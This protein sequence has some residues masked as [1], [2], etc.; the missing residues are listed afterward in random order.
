M[1]RLK[2]EPYLLA[3]ALFQSPS[4]INAQGCWWVMH[5]RP[6]A[7]KSLA[8]RLFGLER[9]FFLPLHEKR[10]VQRG[11]ILSTQLPLFPGYVF[12]HGSEDDRLQA[13]KTNLVVQCLTVDDQPQLHREL[14]NV[15][16]LM[17]SGEILT[18]EDRL[19]PGS[20]VEIIHGSL[21]GMI[22]RVIRR[23]NRLRFLIEVRLLQRG[24]SVEVESWMISATDSPGLKTSELKRTP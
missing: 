13:L 5:T 3:D 9:H 14:Q 11:R 4:P 19:V 12:V 17:R 15:Y 24:V 7:E 8:R 10:T 18:P 22:G 20:P 2:S 1:P 21:S 23:E 6:R 16:L